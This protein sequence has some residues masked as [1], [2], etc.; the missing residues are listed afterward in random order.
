MAQIDGSSLDID[1]SHVNKLESDTL[2]DLLPHV[3]LHD[4]IEV[5]NMVRKVPEVVSQASKYPA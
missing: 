1:Q 3:S 5:V 2:G 4:E